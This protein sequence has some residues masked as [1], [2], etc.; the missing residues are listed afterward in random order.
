MHHKSQYLLLLVLFFNGRTEH[1]MGNNFYSQKERNE[2]QRICMGY[3][4]LSWSAE[5][6]LPFMANDL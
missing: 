4:A 6:T 1:K 3:H 2:V 5:E